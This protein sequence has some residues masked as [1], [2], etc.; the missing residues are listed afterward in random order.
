MTAKTIVTAGKSERLRQF[1][2][3]CKVALQLR[4][5]EL[6]HKKLHPERN[7]NMGLVGSKEFGLKRGE[8]KY[9]MARARNFLAAVDE[10]TMERNRHALRLRPTQFAIAA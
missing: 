2:V 6:K 3:V 8:V 5:V 10:A 4:L 7:S 9:C 1:E